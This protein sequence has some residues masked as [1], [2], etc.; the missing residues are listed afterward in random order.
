MQ[1]GSGD[2][3]RCIQWMLIVFNPASLSSILSGVKPLGLRLYEDGLL[4]ETLGLEISGNSK[5]FLS[6]LSCV[7]KSLNY[8]III[9]KI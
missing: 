6:V 2:R 3:I 8:Q 5:D 1:V 9:N 4:D 7:F